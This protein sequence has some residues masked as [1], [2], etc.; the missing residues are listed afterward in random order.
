RDSP[1]FNGAEKYKWRAVRHGIDLQPV[2]D[3]WRA[4]SP[5]GPF[6]CPWN[7]REGRSTR[8]ACCI[9]GRA[10]AATG[11]RTALTPFFRQRRDKYRYVFSK[12]ALHPTRLG[13]ARG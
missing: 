2:V 12:G 10:G 11:K 6:F 13:V 3:L 8:R 9:R 5:L 7:P 4:K 1:G